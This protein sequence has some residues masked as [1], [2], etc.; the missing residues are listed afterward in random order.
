MPQVSACGRK[1]KTVLY[2]VWFATKNRKWL[3]LGDVEEAAK[4]HMPEIA[5]EKGIRLLECETM[6]DHIHLLLEVS[7]EELPETIRLLKGGSAYKVF[8]QFPEL[9]MAAHSN[10]F[11]QKRY[12]A[13]QVGD[14]V[15]STVAQYIRTQKDRPEKF[16]R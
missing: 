2:H 6:V 1:T 11:W 8:R 14:G 9:K 16:V 15:L 3:L 5:R 10:S 12:G 4:E 7:P 13:K